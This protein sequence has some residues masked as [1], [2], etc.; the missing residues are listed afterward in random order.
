VFFSVFAFLDAIAAVTLS[1]IILVRENNRAL[2]SKIHF[3]C[4]IAIWILTFMS[5]CIWAALYND[6]HMKAAGVYYGAGFGLTVFVW[7]VG[8]FA[9]FLSYIIWKKIEKGGPGQPTKSTTATGPNEQT[10]V[11]QTTSGENNEQPVTVQQ[12]EQAPVYPETTQEN[13]EESPPYN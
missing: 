13:T 9:Y 5:T 4:V 6:A 10:P 11:Q 1:I 7:L 3:G 12:E 8:P 2:V